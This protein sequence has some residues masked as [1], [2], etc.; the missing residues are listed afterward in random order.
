[1]IAKNVNKTKK[2]NLI[3]FSFDPGRVNSIKYI[4]TQS[5]GQ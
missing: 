5:C 3:M 1:M 2:F 4:H